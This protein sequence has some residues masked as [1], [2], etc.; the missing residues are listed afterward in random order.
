MLIVGEVH[1]GLLR[2]R[3]PATLEEARRMAELVAGEAVLVSQRPIEY[4]RSPAA[5]VGVDCELVAP[6]TGRRLRGVGTVL[7]RSAITGGHVVQGSAC[8]TLVPGSG[9]AR[10]PWSYYL[11]CPGVIETLG[12]PRWPEVADALA[13]PGAAPGTLDLGGIAGRAVDSVQRSRRQGRSRLP[14][15][16]TRLRWVAT[17]GAGPVGVRFGLCRD[18]VRL[19]RL[20][21]PE[22]SAETVA[23]VCEDVALHDW[24]LT[25]LIEIVRKAAIGTLD[26]AEALSRL[27]PAVDY[28]LH[29]WMPD[30]RGADLAGEV[31]A[32]LERHPGFSRQ[33]S[34]LVNRIRDQLSVGA[35]TALAAASAR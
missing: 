23:A 32:L 12:R 11:T 25:T 10:R 19:L 27:H 14:S 17:P 35:V 18:D 1:T 2:G 7:G 3:D 13:A 30:A 34:T 20:S 9:S 22:A 29:V 5:P 31:W 26:R 33:W 15:A 21:I 4:V 24:L 8:T 16:R 6:G 28:L